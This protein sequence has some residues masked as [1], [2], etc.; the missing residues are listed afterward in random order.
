MAHDAQ[1]N[2]KEQREIHGAK[3]IGGQEVLVVLVSITGDFKLA[4]ERYCE[5]LQDTYGK[6]H[7][8]IVGAG[9]PYYEGSPTRPAEERKIVDKRYQYREHLMQKYFAQLINAE[10]EQGNVYDQIHIVGHGSP[11][12][13]ITF[14][15]E[16][17]YTGEPIK[18][19]FNVS[20]AAGK[21]ASTSQWPWKPGVR[22]LLVGC[23]TDA[24]PLK[25]FIE[26]DNHIASDVY[27]WEGEFKCFGKF[28]EWEYPDGTIERGE[29]IVYRWESPLQHE[30][31]RDIGRYLKIIE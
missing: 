31:V 15:S 23:D 27:V 25:K 18:E 8:K 26:D 12:K 19:G 16:D 6:G 2:F 21:I 28:P 22:I 9:H 10:H 30:A 3:Y 13:G 17:V 14:Y 1:S 5:L 29:R 11:T 24:G 4:V 20:A 7:V